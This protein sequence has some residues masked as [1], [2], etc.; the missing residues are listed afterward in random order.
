MQS[1]ATVEDVRGL[2]LIIQLFETN[3]AVLIFISFSAYMIVFCLDIKVMFASIAVKSVFFWAQ[4]A[5]STAITMIH[6][7]FLPVLLID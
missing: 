6:P 3:N 7:F 5:Y 4:V 1:V 2:T